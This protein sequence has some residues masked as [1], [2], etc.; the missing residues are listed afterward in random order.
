MK[1]TSELIKK[2]HELTKEIKREYKE[3]DY[4]TQF[5]ICLSYL[6]L[7][8]EDIVKMNELKFNKA[9]LEFKFRN[10]EWKNGKLVSE[11]KITDVDE[12]EENDGYFFNAKYS[13]FKK[14]FSMFFKVNGNMK[15]AV[16]L[17]KNIS[18]DEI[19]KDAKS[20]INNTYTKNT[21]L[22]ISRNSS[23]G[24]NLGGFK[25]TK[26]GSIIANKLKDS[27][28]E[29]KVMDLM[30]KHETDV[31]WGEYTTTTS[32]KLTIGAFKNIISE[33]ENELEFSRIAKEAIEEK[34]IAEIFTKA[35]LAGK[36]QV[37]SKWSEECNDANEQCEVDNIVVYAMPSGDE[38]IERNHTW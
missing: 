3:V 31:D 35:K 28:L 18:V 32:F 9:G 19:I 5:G 25:E 1:F 12:S 37:L 11:W 16:R 4:R 38:V 21:M 15:N 22:N 29:D 33:A 14:A 24:F 23:Y 20:K 17:P 26:Q 27:Q 10:F 34:R 8:K 36:K 2:A 7:N 6:L 30:K 13:E